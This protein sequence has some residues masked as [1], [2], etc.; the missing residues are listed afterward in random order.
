MRI[1]NEMLSR[2]KTDQINPQP[3]SKNVLNKI[4]RNDG[5]VPSVFDLVD[6]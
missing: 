6:F 3:I 1:E 2:F 5:P 4:E